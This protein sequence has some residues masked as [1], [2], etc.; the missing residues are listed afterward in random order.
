M[1][2]LY[3]SVLSKCVMSLSGTQ[4]VLL[5]FQ[6]VRPISWRN[7]TIQSGTFCFAGKGGLERD[8]DRKQVGFLGL[9][10]CNDR[11]ITVNREIGLHGSLCG[12]MQGI[13]S[14]SS[15]VNIF[16]QTAGTYFHCIL[17]SAIIGFDSGMRGKC[18]QS[19]QKRA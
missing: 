5:M 16:P 15:L 13:V 2:F 1:V 9:R 17:Y 11:W 6:N 10:C 8:V 18:S 7:C 19:V 3:F 12:M 4:L 14:T